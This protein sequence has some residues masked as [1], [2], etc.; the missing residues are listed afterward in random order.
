MYLLT[1]VHAPKVNASERV[2]RSVI[3]AI[4]VRSDQKDCD[5]YLSRI[6]FALRSA[7]HSNIGTFFCY[8]ANIWLPRVQHMLCKLN[9]LCDRCIMFNRPDSFQIM[10]S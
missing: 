1:A 7:V 2:N 8:T 6:C 4:R 5:E 10:H 3:A 9:L